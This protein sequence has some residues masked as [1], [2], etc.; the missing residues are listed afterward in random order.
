MA[1]HERTIL[2]AIDLSDLSAPVLAAAAE[3]AELYSARLLVVHCVEL[4]DS[5]YDFMVPEIAGRIEKDAREKLQAELAH[6]RKSNVVPLDVIVEKGPPL[7]VLR[8]TI[9]E[10]RPDL[11]VIGSHGRRGI[12]AMVLG[13]TADK[14]LRMSPSS[15]LVVRPHKN[16][17]IQSIVC[18][19]DFSECSRTALE[20]ALEIAQGEGIAS[21]KVAHVFEVPIGYMEAGMTYESALAKTRAHH[22]KE[23]TEFLKLFDGRPVKCEPAIEE[24]PPA[25]TMVKFAEQSGADLL[26][27]GAHGRSALTSWLFGGVSTSIVHRATMPVLVVKD[28]RHYESLWQ[29]LDRL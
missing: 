4:W 7:P 1:K 25:A 27:I 23:L 2:C 29:A 15:V 16:P 26:V 28:P 8:K 22:Q 17:D 12:D 14:V 11:V 5:R 18:A 3:M 10:R 20:H 24:G 13:N 9:V 6:L 19:V 21:I